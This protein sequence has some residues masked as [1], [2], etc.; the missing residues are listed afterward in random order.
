MGTGGSCA[1]TD[2][3]RKTHLRKKLEYGFVRDLKG[4]FKKR[5]VRSKI[6]K[7]YVDGELRSKFTA[8]F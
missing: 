3:S 6:E 1:A 7:R 5:V 4:Y 2:E 8:G